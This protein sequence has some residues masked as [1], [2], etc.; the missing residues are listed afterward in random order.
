M[1]VVILAQRCETY[2]NREVKNTLATY[3]GATGAA[4]LLLIVA[5]P[6]YGETFQLYTVRGFVEHL[7]E[8]GIIPEP[9]APKARELAAAVR[10]VDHVR[11]ASAPPYREYIDVGVSQLIEHA[12]RTYEAGAVIDGLLVLATNEHTEDV[13]PTA[14]R[15]C[16]ITYRIYDGEELLYDSATGAACATDER[17][18]Y[19][20]APGQTRMFEVR[21][22]PTARALSVGTYTFVLEYPGYGS[23]TLTVTVE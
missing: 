16:Q 1:N 19:R 17:V 23:G 6:A 14:R 7:I 5:L 9:M 8:R 12:S 13:Y 2:E 3:L 22:T 4:T 10:T 11:S 15:N 21:H 18:T 20:L